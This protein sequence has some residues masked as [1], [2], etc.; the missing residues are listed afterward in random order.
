[1]NKRGET[2]IAKTRGGWT[3]DAA[4]I[5]EP[6]QTIGTFKSYQGAKAAAIAWLNNQNR[7]YPTVES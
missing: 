7:W 3:L 6:W 2:Q 4:N 5:G 1:M